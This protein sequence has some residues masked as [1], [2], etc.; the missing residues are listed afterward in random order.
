M[1]QHLAIIVAAAT[2]FA[3]SC[4]WDTGGTDGSKYIEYDIAASAWERTEPASWPE[5]ETTT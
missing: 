3:A 5:G 4:D 1:K 2:L